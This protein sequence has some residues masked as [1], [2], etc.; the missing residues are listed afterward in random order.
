LRHS[1]TEFTDLR[2]VNHASL[3]AE[4]TLQSKPGDSVA[5]A[6]AERELSQL[7]AHLTCPAAA[8]WGQSALR[9]KSRR[10]PRL[11]PVEFNRSIF[12]CKTGWSGSGGTG[13]EAQWLFLP[14]PSTRNLVSIRNP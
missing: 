6:G 9:D 2:A 11:T 7:A 4:N 5:T 3:L 12:S 10:H 1:L 14:E 8:D 13:A